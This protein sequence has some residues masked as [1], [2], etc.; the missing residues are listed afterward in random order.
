MTVLAP[1]GAPTKPQPTLD[2]SLPQLRERI[3]RIFRTGA[4]DLD[5]NEEFELALWGRV[6]LETA[7]PVEGVVVVVLQELTSH[8]GDALDD[9]VLDERED[10]SVRSALLCL[11]SG[12]LDDDTLQ[13]LAELVWRTP[14]E[15]LAGLREA[16]D[17]HG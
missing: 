6:A 11:D 3:Q 4:R 2:L 14:A 1:P 7:E 17:L 16:L 8:L 13:Q 9:A 10:T 5:A 15:R 12:A